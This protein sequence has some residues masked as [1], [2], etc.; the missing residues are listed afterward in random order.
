MYELDM[1]ATLR[2]WTADS[3]KDLSDAQLVK[4][5]DGFNNNILWNAGHL[6]YYQCE[7]TYTFSGQPTPLPTPEKYKGWFAEGTSPKGWTEKP[8]TKFVVELF[9]SI[10]DTILRDAK[11]GKFEGF[12]A[13]SP[14]EGVTLNTFAES[15]GF[16][17]IHEGMHYG[18]I[19]ALKKFVK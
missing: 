13:L 6:L 17:N 11:A 19:G 8:D 18:A 10:S 12:K 9:K 4:I 1:M 3:L 5:P 16:H 14:F 15:V 2:S 7:F